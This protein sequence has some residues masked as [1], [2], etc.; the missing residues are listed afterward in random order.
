MYQSTILNFVLKI[1][2][3]LQ[4]YALDDNSHDLKIPTLLKNAFA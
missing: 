4:K 1:L 3:V 2:V